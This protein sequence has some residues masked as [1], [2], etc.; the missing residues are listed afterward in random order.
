L[1]VALAAL[2]LLAGCKSYAFVLEDRPCDASGACLAGYVCSV[3]NRC[4]REGTAAACQP[5]T[6]IACNGIDEDCNGLDLV[7][8]GTLSNCGG[9]NDTCGGDFVAQSA[10]VSLSCSVTRC[11]PGH[12]D[13]D[14]AASNGCEKNCDNVDGDNLCD[15]EDTCLDKDGDGL[16]DGTAANVGC[17]VAVTDSDDTSPLLCADTDNDQCNDCSSGSYAPT[18]DGVD[19]NGNGLCNVSDTDEDNDGVPH[20]SDSDD[21]NPNVCR[22]LDG[23]GCNDCSQHTGTP[24]V[25]NDGADFDADGLCDAG[26]PDDDNDTV[27]DADDSNDAS[28]TI[29]Q[30]LDGDGCDDCRK[31]ATYSGPNIFD[32]GAVDADRDGLCGPDPAGLVDNALEDC[33]DGVPTC[34]HNCSDSTGPGGDVD[35]IPDCIQ[36]YCREWSGG[37]A[38]TAVCHVVTGPTGA[39]L[40]AAMQTFRSTALPT[41]I[42][43]DTT[44]TLEQPAPT[45]PTGPA[46]LKVVI[47]QRAGTSLN[48]AFASVNELFHF[49]EGNDG[50]EFYGLTIQPVGGPAGPTNRL[51]TVF[52]FE[53]NS[54]IVSGCE[55]NGFE[56]RGVFVEGTGTAPRSGN[57]IVNS[58]FRN[59]TLAQ[60]D[61]DIDTGAIVLS[62][63]ANTRIAGNV[64]LGGVMGAV[65]IAATAGLRIDHNTFFT[66]S[67]TADDGS[68]LNFVNGASSGVCARNNLF[69]RDDTTSRPMRYE[70]AANATWT[71]MCSSGNL[72]TNPDN[73]YC[74]IA[75]DA[76]PTDCGGLPAGFFGTAPIPASGLTNTTAPRAQGFMCL[77]TQHVDLASYTA[78]PGTDYNSTLF[79]QTPASAYIG[80]LFNGD[81]PEPGA[82]EYFTPYC[83]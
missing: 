25:S 23:D 32:D 22:D 50:N 19:L 57:M 79:Q 80:D 47:H 20:P 3:N 18:N 68:A 44:L 28:Q 58:T 83:P 71:S 38:T 81:T 2:F 74:N 5:K 10:C 62:D 6:E 48:V 1:R 41:F 4:V 11:E 72:V 12:V 15:T 40:A 35:T 46:G 70:S 8:T 61:N 45:G 14:G 34:A 51:D 39:Q 66:V 21:D 49:T 82:R 60:V 29:C 75:L 65:T 9:C 30:D 26:D 17:L 54:N 31:F 33:D 64:F 24:S 52:H 73:N 42:F 53:S 59:G 77:K 36:D 76:G 43:I 27:L 55:L 16:G 37:R 13:A 78:V 7:E 69:F 63:T 56:A 67:A